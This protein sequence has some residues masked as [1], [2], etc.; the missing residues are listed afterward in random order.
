MLNLG[1]RADRLSTNVRKPNKTKRHCL[2]YGIP[3]PSQQ[4][5]TYRNAYH[6]P[7]SPQRHRLDKQMTVKSLPQLMAAPLTIQGPQ[8]EQLLH[9][10]PGYRQLLQCLDTPSEEMVIEFIGRLP[11]L[12]ILADICGRGD[13]DSC[14]TYNTHNGAVTLS[15]AFH[16]GEANGPG[17]FKD[18]LEDAIGFSSPRW[19]SANGE[20]MELCGW[21][22]AILSLIF[23]VFGLCVNKRSQHKLIAEGLCTA[24]ICIHQ[25]PGASLRHQSPDQLAQSRAELVSLLQEEKHVENCR[26]QG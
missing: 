3:Y 26:L 9:L 16:S 23:V 12:S 25:S 10:V 18:I 2:T 4:A 22:A 17:G 1:N 7:F 14:I 21:R 8:I 13:G 6:E 19:S 11:Q 5:F 24:T 15:F 20:E